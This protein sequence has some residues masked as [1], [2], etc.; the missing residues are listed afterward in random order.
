MA[1]TSPRRAML[2]LLA[3]RA[4]VAAR[5]IPVSTRNHE[6]VSVIAAIKRSS[7]ATVNPPATMLRRATLPQGRVAQSWNE[8]EEVI[9]Q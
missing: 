2:G 4:D 5:A 6:P 8:S 1:P 9:Q 3:A 7:V